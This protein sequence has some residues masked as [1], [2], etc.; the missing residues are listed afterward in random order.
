MLHSSP[1]KAKKKKKKKTQIKSNI[2]QIMWN[3]KQKQKNI[4]MVSVF[5]KKWSVLLFPSRFPFFLLIQ[6]E[7]LKWKFVLELFIQHQE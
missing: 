6:L 5:E 2:H 4:G 1:R 3:V 7:L